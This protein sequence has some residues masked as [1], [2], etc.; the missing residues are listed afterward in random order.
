MLIFTFIVIQSSANAQT[1]ITSCNADFIDSGGGSSNYLNN[2]NSEWLICPDTTTEYLELEFTHV[3]IETAIDHGIDSTGCKDLLSIYD[4]MDAT[5]PLVGTY[6][7][8]ESGTGKES[9][10]DGHT[11]HV[12]DRFKPTN[13][14]GCFFVKFESNNLERRTGWNAQ[15][16]CCVPSLSNAVTDGIDLPTPA[17]G[18]NYFNLEIDNSCI[19]KGSLDMFTNFEES[20]SSC[21]SA[22][23]TQPNKSFYAFE[24]NGS[25][26]FVEFLTEPVD[27]VGIIEMIVFGPVELDSASYSGGTINDCVVGETPWSLFFNAG[28]NQT[29]I[30]AIATELAGRTSV[31][32]LPSTEGLGGVLPVDVEK[33]NIQKQGRDALI[34]WKTTSEI[35]NEGFEI[36]RSNDFKN[37]SK[38]GTVKSQSNLNQG[39]F[40]SYLDKNL[41]NGTYYY[42][43]KQ[44]DLNGI[45]SDFDILKVDFR[46]DQNL[47]SFPNPS[48]G[49][50]R[51][52]T[53]V[54]LE[55][56]NLV[57]VYNQVGQLKYKSYLS[58]SKTLDISHL[59]S[60]I[61]T[62]QIVAEGKTLS[63]QHVISK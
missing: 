59:E 3:D 19:R 26:G 35:N 34:S 28:P 30:L 23:L 11:L 7:G 36:Y 49:E 13:N 9:F 18:G 6:C 63:H 20:G 43:L 31:T 39:A 4:G 2:E 57:S 5:A 60:G 44:V 51:F 14:S 10:V 21:Y 27:S 25:G 16:N 55:K 50:V 38:I 45:S 12:G 56:V 17:N 42:Y 15:V 32:T 54:D 46:E 40:Y 8:E 53:G 48:N 33:Y 62:I 37:F 22:G 61:Y 24:S 58:R 29:Y 47:T 1:L 41:S 52:K